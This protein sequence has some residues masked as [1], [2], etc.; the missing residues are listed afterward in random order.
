MMLSTQLPR[1]LD[2]HRRRKHGVPPVAGVQLVDRPHQRLGPL[3]WRIEQPARRI[4]APAQA[5]DKA[6]PSGR[7]PQPK[8]AF[9]TNDTTT[10]NRKPTHFLY[11]VIDGQR[12]RKS[13]W[14]Q[15][16]AM[17]HH[18]E[19]EGFNL[20]LDAI[21]VGFDG[22]LVARQP[23]PEEERAQA[24]FPFPDNQNQGGNPWHY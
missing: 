23:R 13:R 7:K 21:P 4:L 11:F 9:I 15:V 6:R 22:R 10:S 1:P 14:V 2:P 3:S 8:E 16:G 5:V 17:F 18:E 19:G 12:G 20:Q 24:L